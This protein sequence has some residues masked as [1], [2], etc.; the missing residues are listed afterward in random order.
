LHHKSSESGK[1]NRYERFLELYSVNQKRVFVYILSLVPNRQDAEDLLQQTMME[2]WKLF[3]RFESGT[4]FVSWGRAIARF[5]VL[6][7]R[8]KQQK[9]KGVLFLNN[10]AFEVILRESSRLP[11]DSNDRLAALSGCL[12]KLRDRD[13]YMLSL[14]YEEGLTYHQ[15]AEKLGRSMTMVYKMMTAIHTTLLHCIHQTLSL[16]DA[17]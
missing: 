8:E 2:M 17:Q 7:F 4:D 6:K 13:K 1:A 5:Q 15:I 12:G 16:W 10:E 9:E 11:D 3:D 14:R